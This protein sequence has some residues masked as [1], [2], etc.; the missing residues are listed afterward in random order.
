MRGL[1]RFTII[2]LALLQSLLF[3]R[4]KKSQ[5]PKRILIVHYLLL[6]DTLLL[7]PL[8]KRI[9]EKYPK[10]KKFI[11]VRPVFMSL[12]KGQPYGFKAL[13]YNPKRFLDYWY[14]FRQGPY[15]LTIVA[16]DNR[17]SWLARALR[18]LWIV[19]IEN[20]K[21]FWKNW[22][23]DE[24]KPFDKSPITWADMIGRL[25]DNKNPKAYQSNEWMLPKSK[26]LPKTFDI[27]VPYVVCHLGASTPLKLWPKKSWQNLIEILNKRGLKI[28]LS[29]GPGEEYLINEVDPNKT[30]IHAAGNLT[31]EEMWILIRDAKLL[32]SVDTGIAH[33]AKFTHTPLATL[34]GPGS[35]VCHGAG[36]FWEQSP[37]IE[38]TS[39]NF[40][41]RDQNILFRRK[42][43]WVKR[44]GRKKEE[45]KTPGACMEIITP[46]QVM[47]SI[48]KNFNLFSSNKL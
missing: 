37:H 25:L 44:C 7:A 45:C 39:N 46:D 30:Y 12:F 1:I 21:P 47:E 31:L 22:M 43:D 20:D 18:C 28:V 9:D 17:Y 24:A 11:L 2:F 16:G 23:V 14:I 32:I 42:I 5:N 38:I 34:F 36:L 40:S 19:G 3:W 10:S 33:I 15:D 26:K 29:A 41:C 6:G 48:V 35:P 4:I 13:S 8:M 27:Y